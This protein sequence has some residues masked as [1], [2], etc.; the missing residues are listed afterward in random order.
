M[1]LYYEME[2]VFFLLNHWYFQ[3]HCSCTHEPLHRRGADHVFTTGIIVFFIRQELSPELMA[4]Q[5]IS[6]AGML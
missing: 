3:C 4:T 6:I 1:F 2:G 5:A